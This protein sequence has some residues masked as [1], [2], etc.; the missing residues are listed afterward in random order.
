MRIAH[1][2]IGSHMYSSGSVYILIPV[3]TVQ[4][5]RYKYKRTKDVEKSTNLEEFDCQ[6]LQDFNLM[7]IRSK[8]ILDL[9]LFTCTSLRF[10]KR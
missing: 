2:D 10:Y 9:T 8:Q 5:W 4:L 3:I 7:Q 6:Q 1:Q